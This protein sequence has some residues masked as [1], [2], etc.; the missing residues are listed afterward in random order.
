MRGAAEG[1]GG[2]P[3]SHTLGNIFRAVFSVYHWV[4]VCEVM[5]PAGVTKPRA[6]TQQ[7]LYTGGHEPRNY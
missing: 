6:S 7:S 2:T 3:H 1:V 5:V 4:I